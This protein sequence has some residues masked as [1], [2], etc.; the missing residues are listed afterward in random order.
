MEKILAYALYLKPAPQ[1]F[2]QNSPKHMKENNKMLN[3][4]Y[5]D[6]PLKLCVFVV[7]Y[8]I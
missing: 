2:L 4:L 3:R 8:N 7:V 6:I 1:F 5:K